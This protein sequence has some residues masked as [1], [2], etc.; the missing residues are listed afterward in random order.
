M[1]GVGVSCQLIDRLPAPWPPC[2]EDWL[3]VIRL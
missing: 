1:I 2:C 3:E